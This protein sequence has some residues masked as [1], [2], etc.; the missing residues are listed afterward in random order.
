MPSKL[1]PCGHYAVPG[2]I[3]CLRCVADGGVKP[4]AAGRPVVRKPVDMSEHV[5]AGV[6]LLSDG[7]DMAI[8]S[9]PEPGQ[10]CPT[11]GHVAKPAAKTQAERARAYRQRKREQG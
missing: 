7:P 8:A 5:P 2:Q 9:P 10:P 4:K 1:L 11:C 3:Q 6:T